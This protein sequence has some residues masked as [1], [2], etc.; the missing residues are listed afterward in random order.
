MPIESSCKSIT[1][2]DVDSDGDGDG[3]GDGDAPKQDYFD[4]MA[5]TNFD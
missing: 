3:D 4:E 2:Q 1:F 5:S